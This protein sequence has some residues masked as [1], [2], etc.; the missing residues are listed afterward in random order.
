MHRGPNDK[1]LGAKT[2]KGGAYGRTAAF[3]NDFGHSGSDWLNT[4]LRRPRDSG[5]ARPRLRTRPR[6]GLGRRWATAALLHCSLAFFAVA[7]NAEVQPMMANSPA[8]NPTAQEQNHRANQAE[9]REAS[10]DEG[11]QQEVFLPS[12][13]ISEDF[14]VPFPVDI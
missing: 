3:R 9:D 5:M 7:L 11:P 1:P 14:A 13:E 2:A 6:S 10:G 4:L 12:E 8:E